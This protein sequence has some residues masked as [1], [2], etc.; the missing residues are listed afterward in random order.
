MLYQVVGFQ[1]KGRL[2]GAFGYCF[3]FGIPK[4][5]FCHR[6]AALRDLALRLGK[7]GVQDGERRAYHKR[8]LLARL[9]M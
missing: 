4:T 3:L 9:G 6:L 1:P 5:Q 7:L 2:I 8:T